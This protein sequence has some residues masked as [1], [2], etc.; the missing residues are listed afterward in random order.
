MVQVKICGIRDEQALKAAAKAGAQFAGFVFYPQSVRSITPE[1]AMPLTQSAPSMTTVGLFV[2]PDN[3][4]LHRVLSLVQLNMIQLHGDESPS[5]V[6]AIK[7]EFGKPVIKALRVATHDDV[8]TAHDYAT[9]ADWLLFDAKVGGTQGGT[10]RAF[11]WTILQ[12]FKTT[13]PWMLAGGLK[14]ENV[15]QALSKLSPTAVDVSSG[16]ESSPGVKDACKITAFV[17]AVHAC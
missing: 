4:W 12:N 17:E 16:V 3:A 13:R 14:P 7:S 5:R 1:A 15:K 8:A 11:D 9:V 10:G 6:A 2:N